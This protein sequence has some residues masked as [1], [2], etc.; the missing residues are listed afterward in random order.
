[1][2]EERI[3]GREAVKRAAYVTPVIITMAA[4]FSFAS[5]GSGATSPRSNKFNEDKKDKRHDKHFFR[6]KDKD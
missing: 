5:A 3:T 2:S 4:N 6:K 1:M